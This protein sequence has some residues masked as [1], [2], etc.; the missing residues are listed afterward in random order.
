L[1]KLV[2]ANKINLDHTSWVF[3]LKAVFSLK[4]WINF[5]IVAPATKL[6]AAVWQRFGL[7]SVKDIGIEKFYWHPMNKRAIEKDR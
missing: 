6:L 5:P 7:K 2:G 3:S 1:D 4:E